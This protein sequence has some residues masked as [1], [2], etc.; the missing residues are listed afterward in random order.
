MPMNVR[1]VCPDDRDRV[2]AW[3]TDETD[4]D[5]CDGVISADGGSAVLWRDGV[6]PLTERWERQFL[7]LGER[8]IEDW[9]DL[10]EAS[11][12]ALSGDIGQ[13]RVEIRRSAHEG[14]LGE[15]LRSAGF[16]DQI[17]RIRK[18]VRVAEEPVLPS[19]A[20]VRL[21]SR[22]EEHFAVH[23]VSLAITQALDAPVP[24]SRV[25]EFTRNWLDEGWS[26]GTLRSYVVVAHGDPVAH[27][28]VSLD[29]AVGELVDL[30][31]PDAHQ[32]SHGWSRMLSTFVETRLALEGAS[33]L[34]GTVVTPDG[35]HPDQLVANLSR[36]GWWIETVS[37]IRKSG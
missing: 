11:L 20:T 16:T 32:R 24:D 1:E 5:D 14:A 29:G 25:R 22:G 36:S 30:V 3:I 23:C 35:V 13:V 9:H 6:H 27:A 17:L 33:L 26:S 34:G 12:G 7:P 19:G 37:M 4:L 18:D 28:L 8:P 10:L 31:V 2:R 15:A 21:L